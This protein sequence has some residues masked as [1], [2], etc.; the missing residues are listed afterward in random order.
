LASKKCH[1]DTELELFFMYGE[2][3]YRSESTAQKA[4]QGISNLHKTALAF[5]SA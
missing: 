2:G 5:L 4:E 1:I 3:K